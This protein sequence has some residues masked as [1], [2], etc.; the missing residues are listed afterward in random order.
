MWMP[1]NGTHLEWL[2]KVISDNQGN[3]A[4]FWGVNPKQSPRDF[5]V[6]H[7]LEDLGITA[8][9]PDFENG[10]FLTADDWPESKRHHE[11]FGAGLLKV[12][13]KAAEKG[14]YTAFLY[15]DALPEW[16]QK[17]KEAGEY[18]TGYDFGEIFSFRLEEEHSEGLD[19]GHVT[20]QS[21]ADQFVAKVRAFADK[22]REAGW[23][24]IMATSANFY[25]DYEILGGADIPVMED[26]AFSHLNMSSALARGLCR[27][28]ELPYWG[29]HLAHEHYSWLPYSSPYKFP[30]LKAS[31]YLKYM[32][33]SRMIVNESANWY[34]QTRHCVDS[35]LYQ[36]RRVEIGSYRNRDPK[37]VAPFVKEARKDFYKIGYHSPV[38][39][40]YRK[41]VSD[42]YNFVKANGTPAGQPETTLALAKGNLDL[43]SHEYAPN[44]A[45]AG[46]YTLAE[47]NPAWYEGA[48]ERGWN[49]AKNVF[50]PR[51]P[52][53]APYRNRFLSGTPYGMV[54]IVS[55]AGDNVTSDFLT[56]HYKALLF[57]GW[58][59]CSE[60]QYQTL[61]EYVT[62]GG[63]LFLSIP[64]LST[65]IS[66]D[67][68][69]YSADE[70]VH[71]GD[72]S[73]LCGVI[74]KGK[75]RRF[76]W[77]VAA[78]ESG[79]L[80]LVFPRR[81]GIM[82]TCIGDIEIT[83]NVDILAVEDEDM[84]PVLLRHRVG[85]GCVYFLNSWAYPG[86]LDQ[87]EGP[88]STIGSTGLIGAVYQHIA[89]ETRGQV[90]ITDDGKAPGHECQYVSYTYFPE[91]G[92]I[93]LLNIDFDHPHRV[94]VHH[95]AFNET[96]SL[97]PGEFRVMDTVVQ[98]KKP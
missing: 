43:C 14:I 47:K 42:F 10:K 67:Y 6:A 69:S 37:L 61:K 31:M 54:D 79:E 30:L 35:P 68:A 16:S 7:A 78:D 72:F 97:N 15:A 13:K 77:A 85:K 91:A 57:S 11:R 38:A 98:A 75:G 60:K 24:N 89:R 12:L 71:Q 41:E 5:A 65:N 4:Q 44:N 50:F 62:A 29:S 32:S 3:L 20:L 36:T 52:I 21:L 64:H 23:G 70:L 93:Y 82:T 34:L 2:E 45:V 95:C 76:Y 73:D 84:G 49:I 87:D 96:V 39:Q 51:P 33:G 58:N 28:Y 26:F 48:P 46:M 74:V 90:W 88:S 86:A 17:F 53:F 19:A 27:Q 22:R 83:G 56:S 92:K 18:Y 80:G 8:P 66:R 40:R 59:T 94:R 63:I 9:E 55:F 81:Y 25:V 1:E